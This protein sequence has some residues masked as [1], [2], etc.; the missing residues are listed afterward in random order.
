MHRIE[1]ISREVGRQERYHVNIYDRKKLGLRQPLEL[2]EELLILSER[3]KKKDLSEKF[4][5]P[6]T[7]N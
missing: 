5:K 7:E 2:G 6:S 3:R 1:R 4:Y